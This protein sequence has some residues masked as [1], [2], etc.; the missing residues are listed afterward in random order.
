MA[1]GMPWQERARTGRLSHYKTQRLSSSGTEAEFSPHHWDMVPMHDGVKE[2]LV[3]MGMLVGLGT[4]EQDRDT[5][6]REQQQRP[7]EPRTPR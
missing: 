4:Q 3:L 7:G 2:R 1:I 5:K 6:Q